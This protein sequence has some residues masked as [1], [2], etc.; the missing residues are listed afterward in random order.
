VQLVSDVTV[1]PVIKY[2][3]IKPLGRSCLLYISRLELEK[4][5]LKNRYLR[6]LGFIFAL[7]A[8]P[9]T[10]GHISRLGTGL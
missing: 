4:Y 10:V 5:N 8:L 1:T 2:I 7:D 9:A 6:F 3:G